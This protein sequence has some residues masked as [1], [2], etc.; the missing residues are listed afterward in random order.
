[1]KG[2]KC[3]LCSKE[4]GIGIDYWVCAECDKSCKPYGVTSRPIC[5]GDSHAGRFVCSIC[6]F[7]KYDTLTTDMKYCFNC[8]VK[9]DWD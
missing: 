6:D 1:M 7:P 9:I 5:A 8:G 2:M 4:L 3:L